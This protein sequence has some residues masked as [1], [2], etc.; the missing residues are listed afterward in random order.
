MG[1]PKLRLAE[2][3]LPSTAAVL[4]P[5]W[6][7][8][9]QPALERSQQRTLTGH[10]FT[11]VWATYPRAV[12]A[13]SFIPEATRQLLHDWWRN[14]YSVAL[15]LDSS[16]FASTTIMRITDLEQPLGQHTAPLAD[17]WSGAIHL[18]GLSNAA[19]GPEPFVLDDS[20]LGMLDQSYNGLL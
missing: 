5:D 9:V 20:V 14:Q 1:V 8:E 2:L 15:T 18:A 11:A 13:L 19:P 6:P 4:Q 3:T 10:L 16:N 12:L 7:L 17:R